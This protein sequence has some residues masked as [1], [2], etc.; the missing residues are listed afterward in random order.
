M[1]FHALPLHND[2]VQHTYVKM[3]SYQTHWHRHAQQRQWECRPCRCNDVELFL[4]S[5]ECYDVHQRLPSHT[6]HG[7]LTTTMMFLGRPRYDQL[8]LWVAC[9]GVAWRG[10]A[11]GRVPSW[12]VAWRR[13]TMRWV[14]RRG[15]TLR[16]VARRRGAVG[17]V[18]MRG[19]ACMGK[20]GRWSK[21]SCRWSSRKRY[22][23]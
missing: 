10:C 4:V 16:W 8:T 18:P 23:I 6:V 21:S 20:E 1:Q 2:H 14:A 9:R 22:A 12:G 7:M 3:W 11:M 15:S 13:G 5:T 17:R 19:I